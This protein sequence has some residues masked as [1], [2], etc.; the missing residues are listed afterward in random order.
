MSTAHAMSRGLTAEWIK[1]RSLRSTYVSMA[2]ALAVALVV[3][4]IDTASVAQHWATLSPSERASFDP[5]G[6]SFDGLQ[7]GV[8]AFGILGVLASSSEYG[9]G[10]IQASLTAVPRRSVF[11]AAK[12]IVVGATSLVLGEL[13]AFGTYFV[14]QVMLSRSGLD[15]SLTDPEVLRA[16]G[17]AGLFLAAVALVGLGLGALIRHTAGAVAV[18]VGLLFV[19]YGLGRALESWSYLPD[20]LLLANASLV[21]GQVHVH[22]DH[23]RR[24][25]S[26]GLAYLDLGLY[27]AVF[28]GLGA[29]RTRRD[30]Q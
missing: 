15:V 26:L 5:V 16:V 29:W 17:S 22:G 24:I 14:G 23:V 3:G 27:L 25:P 4:V 10:L 30:A 28:L 6:T 11:F 8:L 7:F 18:L 13:F 12:A 20:R 19:A 21:I 9:T 1:L 2:S